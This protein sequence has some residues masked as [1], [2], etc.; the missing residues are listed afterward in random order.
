MCVCVCVCVCVYVYV[1]VYAYAYAYAY[2]YLHVCVHVY[3]YASAY[4]YVYVHTY[5]FTYI[6]T[7]I[8]TYICIYMC[9]YVDIYIIKGVAGW[10][11]VMRAGVERAQREITSV[12]IL[13]CIRLHTIITTI[14][15]TTSLG[16]VQLY[17][18]SY[19]CVLICMCPHIIIYVSSY[20]YISS[21]LIL[22]CI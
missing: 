1:Y 12:L 8:H 11:W 10:V 18:S 9:I 15:T 5:L 19:R 4:V 16:E 17:V 3:A 21:V 13:L 2:V 22:L 14:I 6:H 20:Y 7:Y